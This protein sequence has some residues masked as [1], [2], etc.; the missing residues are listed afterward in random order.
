[1]KKIVF[2]FTIV[3]LCSFGKNNKKTTETDF[4]KT[5]LELANNFR[6]HDHGNLV[7]NN[8]SK[9]YLQSKDFADILQNLNKYDVE[10]KNGYNVEKVTLKKYSKSYLDK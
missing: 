2:I 8:N 10:K 9:V 4:S 1:M 5:C 7:Y 6:K 3:I